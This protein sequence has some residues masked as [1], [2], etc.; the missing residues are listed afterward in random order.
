M[1]V[2]SLI[3]IANV[4]DVLHKPWWL[5]C[6]QQQHASQKYSTMLFLSH[7]IPTS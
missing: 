2:I 1:F 7:I 3:F 4:G 5:A 6:F